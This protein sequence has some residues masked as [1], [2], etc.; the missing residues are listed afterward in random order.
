MQVLKHIWAVHLELLMDKT[1]V[2]YG[3]SWKNT[4]QD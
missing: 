2:V 1:V 4:Q 3:I